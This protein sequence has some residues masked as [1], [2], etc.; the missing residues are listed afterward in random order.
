MQNLAEI[1]GI[2]GVNQWSSIL[3]N[4]KSKRNSFIYN[5]DQYGNRKNKNERCNTSTEAIRYSFDRD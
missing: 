3:N 4:G 5:I 1:N 2:D